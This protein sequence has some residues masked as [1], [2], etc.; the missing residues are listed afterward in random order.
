MTITKKDLSIKLKQDL[1]LKVETCDLL[2]DDIFNFIK[3]SLRKNKTI[4]LSGF[5]TF[6]VIKSKERIGRNPKTME[7]FLI[8]SRSKVKFKSTAK[9]KQFLN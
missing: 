4:K 6:N 2:V 9:A 1:N 3:F 7:S 5:G 8:P